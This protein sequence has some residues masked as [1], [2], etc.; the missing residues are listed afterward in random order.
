MDNA[1]PF[2]KLGLV[3]RRYK[4]DL[5]FGIRQRDRL[6]HMYVI[7]QTGTGKSTLLSNLAWQDTEQQVGYCFLDPHGD[8]AK[9]LSANI[10]IPH[11]YWDAADPDCP[12]GYNPLTHV[13]AAHRPVVVSGLISTLRHLWHD[14]WGPRME[15]LLRY[16]L[17][18]LM[19]VPGST[20]RDIVPLL[21]NK[22]RQKDFVQRLKDP[23]VRQFWTEEYPA[24]SHKSAADGVAPIANKVGA[25]LSHPIIRKAVCEPK[26][27]LRL[28]AIMDAGQPLIINLAK[29]RIG[30]DVTNVLGGLII[31]SITNA[32]FS[33]YDLP[34][35]KRRHFVLYVDEFSS[36]ASTAFAAI[37]SET[38]KYGLSVVLGNQYVQ[39][40]EASV[41]E[42]IMGNIGTLIVYRIGAL[43]A[44]LFVQQL[45]TV[46]THDLITLPNY[47][48]YMQLMVE[49]QKSKTFSASMLPP[50]YGG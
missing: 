41:F 28:R 48:T 44:P 14:S 39:Q 2:T 27:P 33:R 7:G 3:H 1:N 18:G 46:T 21:L 47:R 5:P 16:T 32:A 29:G 13:A 35:E 22:D 30:A 26:E 6:F 42:A 43:D 15:H 17:L 34:E 23:Q 12:F 9:S 40:V 25:F 19:E 4:S 10:Q 45:E 50:L 11:L 49:G 38:R 24:M 36:F 31:S 8:Q 20:L 37:L